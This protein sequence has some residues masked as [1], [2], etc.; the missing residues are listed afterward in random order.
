[1]IAAFG[2]NE[3]AP[4]AG[5]PRNSTPAPQAATLVGLTSRSLLELAIGI[6]RGF[7]FDERGAETE[8][9]PLGQMSPRRSSNLPLLLHD[10]ANLS[11]G[12]LEVLA[13]AVSCGVRR[14]DLDLDLGGT[15]LHWCSA[16]SGRTEISGLAALQTGNLAGCGMTAPPGETV[17]RISA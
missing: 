7:R 15:F 17:Q 16:P 5:A 8:H 3:S 10:R 1:V 12:L 13:P 11:A 6:N 4:E 14:R 2:R 9:C